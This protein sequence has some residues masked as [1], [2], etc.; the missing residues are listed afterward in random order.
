MDGDVNAG[1]IE[2]SSDYGGYLIRG[3]SG[4]KDNRQSTFKLDISNLVLPTSTSINPTLGIHDVSRG[5][6]VLQRPLDTT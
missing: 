6:V 2:S 4:R 3:P 1:V 5:L